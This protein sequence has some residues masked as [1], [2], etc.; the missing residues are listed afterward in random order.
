ML[1]DVA[2]KYPL[3]C[4]PCKVFSALPPAL[5][6]KPIVYTSIPALIS[7]PASYFVGIPWLPASKAQHGLD[8]FLYKV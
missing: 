7:K 2:G 6:S 1:A 3:F 4:D 8:F 5:I